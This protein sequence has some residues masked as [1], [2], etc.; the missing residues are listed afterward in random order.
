MLRRPR[1][2]GDPGVLGI[3]EGSSYST[4]QTS[5]T[6]EYR[7]NLLLDSRQAIGPRIKSG[8]TSLNLFRTVVRSRRDDQCSL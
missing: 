7:D 3:F 4:Q 5:Q 1:A 6:T 2:G 8:A